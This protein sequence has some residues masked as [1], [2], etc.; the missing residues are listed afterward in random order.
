MQLIERY[1][2]EQQS[3]SSKEARLSA[4]L[5]WY[6][7]RRE[8]AFFGSLADGRAE[9]TFQ[10]PRWTTYEIVGRIALDVRQNN[11]RVEVGATNSNR[12]DNFHTASLVRLLLQAR[13]PV[14]PYH[15]K[16][17]P[18]TGRLSCGVQSHLPESLDNYIEL[19]ELAEERL[20]AIRRRLEDVLTR[21]RELSSQSEE[22]FYRSLDNPEK[23]PPV[24]KQSLEEL[25]K[26]VLSSSGYAW[27]VL[28]FRARS[29]EKNRLKQ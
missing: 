29:L 10:L 13:Q 8:P 22:E 11:L 12:T 9:L 16:V 21:I 6:I 18:Q 7:R 26:Y 5:C 24:I 1:G 3:V 2:L 19:L 25:K 15:L 14:E 20:N 4:A 17:H 23:D 27:K 28:R